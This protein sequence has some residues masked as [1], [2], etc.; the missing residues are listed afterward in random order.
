MDAIQKIIDKCIRSGAEMAEVYNLASKSMN[1]RVRNGE[2]EAI[3]KTTP[4]GIAIRYFSFGK[5]AFAHTTEDPLS[6]RFDNVIDALIAHLS[7]TIKSLGKGEQ[8]ALPSDNTFDQ[9]T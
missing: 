8:F 2:V 3:Q 4:G 7:K 5:T 6:P 9:R 1:I